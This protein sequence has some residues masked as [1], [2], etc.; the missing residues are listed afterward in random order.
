M[1]AAIGSFF[2]HLWFPLAL[3]V[4]FLL[5]LPGFIVF[6]CHIFGYGEETNAW[7]QDNFN[8]S[9][10]LALNQWFTL[11]LF[12]LPFLILLLYFLKLKRK[13]LQVPSTFLWQK[14]I[15]DLHVNALLQWLRRNILLLLQLLIVIVLIY[16]VMGFRVYGNLSKGKHYIIM[17]DNSASMNIRDTDGMTRLEWAKQEALKEIDAATD[18]DY[19]MIVSFNS[20]ASL[21]QTYTSNRAQ[22]R[23]AVRSIQP[24]KR[25]TRIFDAIKLADS[26]ANPMQSIENIAS[27]P[28]NVSPEKERQVDPVKGIS[29]DVLLFSDGRF[30]DLSEENLNK[31]NPRQAG[32]TNPLGEINLHYRRVG[33]PDPS[34]INNVGIVDF[35]AVRLPDEDGTM[36]PDFFKINAL[37]RIQNYSSKIQRVKVYVDAYAYGKLVHP[38]QRTVDLR[39]YPEIRKEMQKNKNALDE[40]E[41]IVE[42]PTLDGRQGIVLQANL[43]HIKDDFAS[44]N[45]AWVAFGRMRKANILIVGPE[46]P[47]FTAF[48]KQEAVKKVA[49]VNYLSASDLEEEKYKE[50]ASSGDYDLII[51]DRC[52]PKT[53]REMPQANSFFLG[54]FPPPWMKSQKRLSNP[55]LM[56]NKRTHPLLRQITTFWEVA[57]A[58]VV[59]FDVYQD[60]REDLRPKYQKEP[61]QPGKALPTVIPLI[62]AQ[63][64]VPVLFVL[65][66]GSFQDLVLTF[67]IIDESGALTTNWPLK[68]SFPLFMRNVLYNLGNIRVPAQAQFTLAGQMKKLQPE[69]GVKKLD[70]YSPKGKRYTLERKQG[71]EFVF[72]DTETLGIY[73]VVRD[74]KARHQFTVSLLDEDESNIVPRDVIRFGE[75]KIATGEERQQ[76]REIW[77]WIVL[78][79]LFLLLLEWYIYNKRVFV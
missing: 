43:K 64:N 70:I 62:E 20:T 68:P 36:N 78:A 59:P 54:Q 21:L 71:P 57:V 65:P 41:I 49:N 24:T 12:L 60:L 75:E 53:K 15:E 32:N 69:A 13:P 40:G 5:A 2:K 29:T 35:D 17:I 44:D 16:A 51:F 27:Q 31:L 67:P 42:I 45:E 50:A 28:E 52:A 79:G 37:I 14:S 33:K 7:L 30:P 34:E 47:V 6:A 9:Y 72:T 56:V 8:I 38:E 19:G 63:G 55:L 48:F 1:F 10:H 26:R 73:Q 4:L 3:I 58:E 18:S 77:Q 25:T 76:P 39:P 22:L 74:D 23:Q 46:N 66:R 61:G 11:V